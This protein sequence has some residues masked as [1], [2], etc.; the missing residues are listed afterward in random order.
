MKYGGESSSF[1]RKP[2]GPADRSLPQ[3]ISLAG[4]TISALASALGVSEPYA[5]DIRAGPAP[6]YAISDIGDIHIRSDSGARFD[7]YGFTI[8]QSALQFGVQTV[9]ATMGIPGSLNCP[10]GMTEF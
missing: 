7:I 10:P 5:V 8:L 9:W 4:V 3:E 6:P 1:L 2:A